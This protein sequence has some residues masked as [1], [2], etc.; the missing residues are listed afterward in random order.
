MSD[1]AHP[2]AWADAVLRAVLS[3]E[4]RENVS[5]D[6][7]EEYRETILPSRGRAAACRWYIVQVAGFVWRSSW[8]FGVLLATSIIGRDMLDWWL[9]PTDEFYARSIVSTV[10]AVLLFAAVGFRTAWRSRSAAGGALAGVVAG[11][12]SALVI[13]VLSA[14]QL[15]VWHDAHTMAMIRASGGLGEVFALPLILIVPG[16]ACAA[17]GAVVGKLSAMAFRSVQVKGDA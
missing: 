7:L 14:A 15:A 5:G 12:I 2:P 3:L 6:L 17:S 4:H 11:T 13:N 8:L 16:T 10:I 1:T 9:S